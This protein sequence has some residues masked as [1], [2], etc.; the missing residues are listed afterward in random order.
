MHYYLLVDSTLCTVVEYEY[1]TRRCRGCRNE[2]PEAS[3]RVRNQISATRTRLIP[4]MD[5]STANI[6]MNFENF[7][8]YD[9]YF[10]AIL[11]NKDR[12]SPKSDNRGRIFECA[13]PY[14][15]TVDDQL[16]QTQHLITHSKSSSSWKSPA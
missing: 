9:H 5:G 16:T 2:N 14:G 11:N 4:A 12:F 13:Y 7:D 8:S 6:A 10:V 15:R 3:S 1:S